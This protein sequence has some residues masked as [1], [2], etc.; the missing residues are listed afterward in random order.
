MGRS[1]DHTLNPSGGICLWKSDPR[2]V[3]ITLLDIDHTQV[4][5]SQL[6]ARQGHSFATASEVRVIKPPK[7]EDDETV[8]DVPR[9][10]Q[11]MGE[12]I[13]SGNIVMKEVRLALEFHC[14]AECILSLNHSISATLK[15]RVR[16]SEAACS[17]LAI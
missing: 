5:P 15:P 9:D 6:V 7:D 12:I 2:S 8:E 3:F 13:M 14:F 16:L 4:L 1:R 17:I 10:G 11:T